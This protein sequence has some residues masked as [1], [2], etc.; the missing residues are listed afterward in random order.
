MSHSC[1]A[2][3]PVMPLLLS[4]CS[5]SPT[6]PW[7]LAPMLT[8]SPPRSLRCSWNYPACLDNR[9]RRARL[10][11]LSPIGI[12]LLDPMHELQLPVVLMNRI[13]WPLKLLVI[14]A[15]TCM[16]ATESGTGTTPASPAA[17]VTIS[18][19][20]YA[21][22]YTG[23]ACSAALSTTPAGSLSSSAAGCF[24]PKGREAGTVS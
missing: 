4:P 3:I 21:Y 12:E 7:L 14:L 13:Q 22:V 24:S 17:S 9:V 1:H 11:L 6:A 19:P 8:V 15:L 2:P 10:A 20:T 23:D 16:G 5:S 18:V